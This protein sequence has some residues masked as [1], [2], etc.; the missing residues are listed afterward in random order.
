MGG[1]GRGVEDFGGCG[2]TVVIDN[3]VGGIGCDAYCDMLEIPSC[4]DA[5]A[6]IQ[7]LPLWR[8]SKPWATWNSVRSRESFTRIHNID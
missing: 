2:G 7:R 3:K 1:G 6:S 4:L 5:T 8:E